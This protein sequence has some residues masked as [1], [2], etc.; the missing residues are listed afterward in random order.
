MRYHTCTK[1][2]MLLQEQMNTDIENVLYTLDRGTSYKRK[3]KH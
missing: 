3:G 2:V 1:K